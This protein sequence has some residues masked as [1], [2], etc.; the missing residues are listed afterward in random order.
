MFKLLGGISDLNH[1]ICIWVVLSIIYCKRHRIW[2]VKLF[3]G[4]VDLVFGCEF[5]H[6]I[7]FLFVN[8]LNLLLLIPPMIQSGIF[9]IQSN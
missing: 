4:W 5:E 9:V 7:V 1:T 8:N 6:L 3:T 2:K